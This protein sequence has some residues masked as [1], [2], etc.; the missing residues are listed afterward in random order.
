M[1]GHSSAGGGRGSKKRSGQ[2]PRRPRRRKKWLFITGMWLQGLGCT[3]CG[4]DARH[5]SCMWRWLGL[6][7]HCQGTAGSTLCGTC[8]TASSVCVATPRSIPRCCRISKFLAD[9]RTVCWFHRRLWT[10]NT[11]WVVIPLV[12]FWCCHV[13][14]KVESAA[15]RV[16]GRVA[17]MV[18]ICVGRVGNARPAPTASVVSNGAD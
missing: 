6:C 3:L 15:G 14:P 12:D 11:R 18:E 7:A 13:T 5:G 16:L 8:V 1:I 4:C 10:T 9:G 17:R 2:W